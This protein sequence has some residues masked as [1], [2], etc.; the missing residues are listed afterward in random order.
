MCLQGASGCRRSDTVFRGLA[1]QM[2][3]CYGWTSKLIHSLQL[4]E[5][6]ILVCGLPLKRRWSNAIA[7]RPS[8]TNVSGTPWSITKSSFDS[9]AKDSIRLPGVGQENCSLAESLSSNQVLIRS[10]ESDWSMILASPFIRNCSLVILKYQQISNDGFDV[11][12]SS[13]LLLESVITLI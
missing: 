13:F 4:I 1:K 9:F 5:D 6:K 2:S 8:N 12:S 7:C 11:I 10:S 3:R